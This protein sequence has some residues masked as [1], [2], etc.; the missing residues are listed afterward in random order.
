MPGSLRLPEFL[1]ISRNLI[2]IKHQ[3]FPALYNWFPREAESGPFMGTTEKSPLHKTDPMSVHDFANIHEAAT[4]THLTWRECITRYHS[5]IPETAENTPFDFNEI[6]L[7]TELRNAA[8]TF[9]RNID[10]A[11]RSTDFCF[12]Y[13]GNTLMLPSYQKNIKT[14]YEQAA[15][16]DSASTLSNTNWTRQKLFKQ[17]VAQPPSRIPPEYTILWIHS[18]ESSPYHHRLCFHYHYEDLVTAQQGDEV[19]QQFS[20]NPTPFNLPE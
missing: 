4:S 19:L 9:Q 17:S 10:D 12:V 20:Q 2:S 13:I 18:R 5:F 3:H 15:N 6:V 16:L 7:I 11:S 8:Q 14:A 1:Y